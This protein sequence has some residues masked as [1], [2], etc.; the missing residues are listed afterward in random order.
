M[1]MVPLLVMW[2]LN[3]VEFLWQCSGRCLIIFTFLLLRIVVT[4][5]DRWKI[6]RRSPSSVLIVWY[7]RS[8]RRGYLSS[9]FC[10]LNIWT[11]NRILLPML[12]L[13]CLIIKIVITMSRK[14]LTW[15]R[16]NQ[17]LTLLRSPSSA[18]CWSTVCDKR[19]LGH[20]E[21]WNKGLEAKICVWLFCRCVQMYD[22][23]GVNQ[24]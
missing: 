22:V 12:F 3:P 18:R 8:C 6:Q 14:C 21:K 17:H 13:C 9:K 20:A 23:D 16:V 24:I 19:A 2:W 15:N 4:F 11:R 10:C 5:R 7:F 1:L